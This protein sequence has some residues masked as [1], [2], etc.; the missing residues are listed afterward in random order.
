[1]KKPA[2][3]ALR[4]PAH[5]ANLIRGLHPQIKRKLRAALVDIMADPHAGKPLKDDLA[6]LW[7]FRV[8]KFRI[9]Y[10]IGDRAARDRR[11][12]LVAC[13]PRERIYEETYRLVARGH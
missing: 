1:M 11:I 2:R 7:S 4:V 3:Y 12:E 8:G 6:G 9:V 5:V 10:R 13:G